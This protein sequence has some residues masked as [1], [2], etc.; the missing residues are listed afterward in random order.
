MHL[1]AVLNPGDLLATG[2]RVGVIQK[3][4]TLYLLFLFGGIY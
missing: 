1:I 3:T 4:L 2:A